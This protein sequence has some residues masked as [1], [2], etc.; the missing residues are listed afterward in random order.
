MFKIEK[1]TVAAYIKIPVEKSFT[2]SYLITGMMRDIDAVVKFLDDPMKTFKR[3]H[4][5]DEDGVNDFINNMP[6]LNIDTRY[7]E[8]E[9]EEKYEIY[10]EG[11]RKFHED[12]L[13]DAITYIAGYIPE[14]D[15]IYVCKSLTGRVLCATNYFNEVVECYYQNYESFQCDGLN[16]EELDYIEQIRFY[17]F[18]LKLTQE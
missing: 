14:R 11:G 17:L 1:K 13:A 5:Y 4:D 8:D 2:G 18:Q 9:I 12:T 3:Y 10:D 15:P 7:L 6:T 16:Q